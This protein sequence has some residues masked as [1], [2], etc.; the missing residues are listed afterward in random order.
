MIDLL[1]PN[2]TPEER[3]LSMATA[4]LG[5]PDT[6]LGIDTLWHPW[7]CPEALLPWLAWALA[8][9]VWD[10]EWD[11][12]TKRSVIA[13]SFALRRRAGTVWAVREALKAAGYADARLMESPPAAHWAEFDLEVDIGETEGIAPASIALLLRVLHTAKP[14]SRRLRTMRPVV[15]VADDVTM[16]DVVS[17]SAAL[18]MTDSAVFGARHDGAQKYN[19]TIQHTGTGGDADRLDINVTHV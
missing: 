4:R 16:A 3:A 12:A 17:V 13:F 2:A 8:V 6:A 18:E 10:A 7:D 1:P 15:N 19:Q 11:A 14:V 5:L 9:D